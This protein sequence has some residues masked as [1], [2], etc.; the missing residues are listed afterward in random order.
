MIMKK[1]IE[2]GF[3]G[4]KHVPGGECQFP[5]NPGIL[6]NF[7]FFR[8]KKGIYIYFDCDPDER[9]TLVGGIANE[10]AAGD[11]E[12]SSSGTGMRPLPTWQSLKSTPST[13]VPDR[14]RIAIR[15]PDMICSPVPL[16]KIT[17][18]GISVI[19]ISATSPIH[20]G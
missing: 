5:Q 6:F 2:F 20:L 13:R 16:C 12:C 10:G 8:R 11:L 15:N 18:F 14:R 1:G 3:V 17:I 7:P 9:I 19:Y 4:I